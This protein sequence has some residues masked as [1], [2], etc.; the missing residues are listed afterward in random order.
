MPFLG[1]KAV[2]PVAGL[3]LVAALT[4]AEH[5]VTLDQKDASYPL[6]VPEAA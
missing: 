3:R 2:L 5:R 6:A 1:V 4:P